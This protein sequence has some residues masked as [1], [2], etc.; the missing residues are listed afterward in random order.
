MSD[1]STH[2]FDVPL[3]GML[4][5][6]QVREVWCGNLKRDCLYDPPT[7]DW[8]A[9]ADELNSRA[10]WT[11]RN[12]QKDVGM[13]ECSECG[14]SGITIKSYWLARIEPVRCPNCGAKVVGE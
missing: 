8:Q 12:K 6:E 9:I 13:F 11:C 2:A 10:E 3:K 4:T 14:I 5:A 7:P 1:C